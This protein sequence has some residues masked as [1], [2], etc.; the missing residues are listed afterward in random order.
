MF[1]NVLGNA[2]VYHTNGISQ[3]GGLTNTVPF[4]NLQSGYYWSVTELAPNASAAWNFITAFGYQTST[5]I[6]SPTMHGVCSLVMLVPCLYPQQYGYSVQL[7][8]VFLTWLRT[9]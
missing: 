1:Y 8:L 4:S 5:L 7:F 3:P 2:A 9:K 6:T